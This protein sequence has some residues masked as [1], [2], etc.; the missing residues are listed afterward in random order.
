MSATSTQSRKAPMSRSTPHE[1]FSD[2]LR[3]EL[4]PT[5]RAVA[6]S[7]ESTAYALPVS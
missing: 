1:L 7:Q 4:I 6:G 3:Q 2:D 5:D